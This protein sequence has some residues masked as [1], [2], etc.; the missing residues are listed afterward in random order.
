[1]GDRGGELAALPFELRPLLLRLL[2]SLGEQVDVVGELGHLVAAGET[3]AR[4]VAPARQRADRPGDAV[5]AL[6]HRRGDPEAEEHRD[7]AAEDEQR[8]QQLQIVGRGDEHEPR[9]DEDVE[10]GDA[11]RE[12]RAEEGLH[13]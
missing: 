13:L 7:D 6:A 3:Q 11:R 8:H 12:R 1:M 4:L 9:D 10:E 2:E 5:D